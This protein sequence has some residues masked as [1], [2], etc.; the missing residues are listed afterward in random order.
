MAKWVTVGGWV[1]EH[2]LVSVQVTKVI[3]GWTRLQASDSCVRTLCMLHYTSMLC[4][5]PLCMGCR[6]I[7]KNSHT[8]CVNFGKENV[9]EENAMAQ[10]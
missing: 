7:H 3:V 8:S 10:V 4:F 9:S 1:M 6:I 5:T 2:I